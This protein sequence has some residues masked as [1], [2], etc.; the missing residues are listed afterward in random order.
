MLFYASLPMLLCDCQSFIKESY[1]YYYYVINICV[2]CFTR[3]DVHIVVDVLLP[4]VNASNGVFI[5]AR[6]D[7][8]GCTTFLAQGIFL[9]VL[10]GD[11]QVI[12]STD[13]GKISYIVISI[14]K[15]IHSVHFSRM[16]VQTTVIS[17]GYSI[18]ICYENEFY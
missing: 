12:I 17:I 4:N 9:Y 1:Y 7:Q 10:F 5:A 6:M 18:K 14:L 2:L 16:W 13:L 8:G 15:I 3:S 11:N